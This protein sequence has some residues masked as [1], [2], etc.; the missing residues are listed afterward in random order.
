MQWMLTGIIF[1]AWRLD[2][3]FNNVTY[4]INQGPECMLLLGLPIS[5]MN[6]DVCSDHD[7]RPHL[8][9]NLLHCGVGV[10]CVNLCMWQP[11][12]LRALAGNSMHVYTLAV[13]IAILMRSLDAA[14]LRRHLVL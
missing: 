3:T 14:K 11:K 8:D 4:V 7:S 13:A 10:I 1:N 5:S 2:V 12:D 9:S 6:L